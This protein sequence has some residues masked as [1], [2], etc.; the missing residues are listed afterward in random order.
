MARS[1]Q[2]TAKPSKSSNQIP[3]LQI[4][5]IRF[6]ELANSV[7]IHRILFE[8][9]P[10]TSKSIF[11]VSLGSL[12]G[13]GPPKSHL[14]GSRFDL[15]LAPFRALG[16]VHFSHR[17]LEILFERKGWHRERQGCVQAPERGRKK[18]GSRHGGIQGHVGKSLFYYSETTVLAV[19]GA[20]RRVRTRMFSDKA[21]LEAF[22][23]TLVRIFCRLGPF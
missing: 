18:S 14:N 10:K 3:A 13:P 1:F 23:R 17:F 22:R 12:W 11:L 20:A 4:L 8:N 15:I 5:E 7:E 21:A 16:S 2:N 9:V 6:E 19:W